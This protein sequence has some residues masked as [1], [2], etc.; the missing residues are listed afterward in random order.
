MLDVVEGRRR[1]IRFLP[2]G[3]RPEREATT[4]SQDQGNDETDQEALRV[5]G[6]GGQ[7]T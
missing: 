7:S 6:H 3:K 2:R 4:T 1:R 5:A